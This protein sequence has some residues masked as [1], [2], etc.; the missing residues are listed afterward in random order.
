MDPALLYAS[1]FIDLNPQSVENLF[2]SAA[3]A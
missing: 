3:V 2:T 1:P